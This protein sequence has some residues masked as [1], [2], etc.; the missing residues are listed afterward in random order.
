MKRIFHL[1]SFFTTLLLVLIVGVIE[2]S[3]AGTLSH[4][5]YELHNISKK[6]IKDGDIIQQSVEPG[7]YEYRISRLDT[8]SPILGKYSNGKLRVEKPLTVLNITSQGSIYLADVS[9]SGNILLISIFSK[10][11]TVA[12]SWQYWLSSLDAIVLWQGFDIYE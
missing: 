11:K 3:Q 8:K 5:N 10:Q 6:W 7:R 2:T 9:Q 12:M 1:N 4:I